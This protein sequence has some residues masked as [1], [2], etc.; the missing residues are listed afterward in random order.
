MT[1][2]N[3]APVHEIRI[4]R[5]RA[6]IWENES[7]SGTWHN[8]TLSRIYKEGNEWKDSTGFGRDDLPIVA[9]VADQAHSWIYA[10]RSSQTENE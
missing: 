2:K 3:N 4:G 6:T 7:T 1:D 10:N 9:K 5:I 8:V